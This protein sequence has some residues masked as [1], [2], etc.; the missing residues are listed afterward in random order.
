RGRH[1]D[2]ERHAVADVDECQPDANQN[3]RNEQRQRVEIL[4]TRS[5]RLTMNVSA[6]RAKV[7]G[8]IRGG[9]FSVEWLTAE[10]A[11]A[12]RQQ[13]QLTALRTHVRLRRRIRTHAI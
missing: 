4:V 5:R 6:V 9:P 1:D 13:I 10:P 3:Q 11:T 8:P 7:T 2:D 12:C